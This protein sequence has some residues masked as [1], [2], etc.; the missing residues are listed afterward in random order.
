MCCLPEFCPVRMYCPEDCLICLQGV[1]IVFNGWALQ[2]GAAVQPL[3]STMLVVLHTAG[4]LL[5]FVVPLPVQVS[6]ANWL[7]L[8][9]LDEGHWCW[10]K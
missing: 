10:S 1:A 2:E 5:A 7:L 4:A 8:G 6:A 9:G 3:G